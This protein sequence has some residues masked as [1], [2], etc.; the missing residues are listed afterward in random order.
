MGLPGFEFMPPANEGGSGA[1]K[2]S[3]RG[4]RHGILTARE[5]KVLASEREL[6]ARGAVAAGVA[7]GALW[8]GVAA[9]RAE[10]LRVAGRGRGREGRAVQ[11]AAVLAESFAL[12][13]EGQGFVTE[14]WADL[15]AK[16]QPPPPRDPQLDRV[17]ADVAPRVHHA[18][19][20]LA[21]L[22]RL[23]HHGDSWARAFFA[24][25]DEETR[26]L[27]LDTLEGP[28]PNGPAESV[29]LHM[30]DTAPR[31]CGRLGLPVPP[32][33][34]GAGPGPWLKRT[35]QLPSW[36]ARLASSLAEPKVQAALDLGR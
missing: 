26:A 33:L 4:A 18:L 8:S 15:D 10:A 20:D 22:A 11:T 16:M 14:L 31:I 23:A 35:R 13:A 7:Q 9:K 28:I 21:D 2:V 19:K 1:R 5:R 12:P 32:E 30:A 24:D 6:D 29:S 27:L 36:E 3:R 34:A 25:L 17:R